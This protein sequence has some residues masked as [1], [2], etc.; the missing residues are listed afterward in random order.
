MRVLLAAMAAM[1]FG[2][3]APASAE[4]REAKT[5][6][7]LIYS[8]DNE[9]KLH[10]F[11]E[12]L[13]AVHALMLMAT[14]KQD[15]E[16]PYPVRV[17]V[18]ADTQAVQSYMEHPNSNVAG[19]Y[20]P[21]VT[22][23]I[24]ITPRDTGS[25]DASFSQQLVL[26]H[27]YAHHFMLQYF[28]SAY[29]A[30]Y[31]EGWAELVSTASFE[32]PGYI[33][34]GKAADHRR[35]EL[36]LNDNL[37]TATRLITVRQ[38]DL[39]S[40]ERSRF[41][42]ASWLL[43]HFLTFDDKRRGQLTAYLAAFNTGAS[44]ADAAKVFGDPRTLDR[45]LDKYLAGGNFSYRQP[46][47]PADVGRNITIRILAADESAMLPLEMEFTKPMKP[48]A[49]KA[50]AARV[51]AAAAQFPDG[52]EAQ[53]LAAEVDLDAGLLDPAE[54]AARRAVALAPGNARARYFLGAVELERA[55]KTDGDKRTTLAAAG[56][57]DV[58][59]ANRL[60]P[61]DPLPLIGF[62]R[63][64]GAAGRA[65]PEAGRN[66]LMAAVQIVPQDGNTRLMLV[67][68]L[69]GRGDKPHAIIL[70][71]PLAY[72]VHGGGGSALALKMLDILEGRATGDPLAVRVS[73]DGDASKP[74]AKSGN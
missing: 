18:V 61:D 22:G 48:D 55:E 56:K 62:Y 39:N 32:K 5:K 54:R 26:F 52:P 72:D 40:E 14:G 11:A 74:K 28:P 47:V 46:Q 30:W 2:A 13:E 71:K 49:A 66:A 63:S 9:A 57:A 65:A 21:L 31:V 10:K 73:E 29:P 8:Q 15:Q 16:N 53:M 38:K 50:F 7:F 64:F 37:I 60:D 33:S 42:G 12:R 23:P 34:Y 70:L 27:E 41:Y 6:H 19:F 59:A 24:A 68:D 36:D 25:N 1:L 51:E 17:Y 45:D 44:P 69:L 67:R 58:L 3:A 4:W 20:R 35:Y 43:T